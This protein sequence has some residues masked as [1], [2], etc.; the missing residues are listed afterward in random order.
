[1]AQYKVCVLS[2]LFGMGDVTLMAGEGC[3]SLGGGTVQE[4]GARRAEDPGWVFLVSCPQPGSPTH[5]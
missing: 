3:G 4:E 1:M 2:P 5:S